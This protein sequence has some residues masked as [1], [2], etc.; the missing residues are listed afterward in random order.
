M[1][2]FWGRNIFERKRD[3]AGFGREGQWRS[4][5]ASPLPSPQQFAMEQYLLPKWVLKYK[6]WPCTGVLLSHWLRPSQRK[7][8]ISLKSE[9]DLRVLTAGNYQLTTFL[10]T[11]RELC[12]F[13]FNWNIVDLECSISFGVQQSESVIHIHVSTF[14]F[15]KILFPY[16]LLQSIKWSSLCCTVGPY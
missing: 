7:N 11:G 4:K 9:V 3:R 2:R 1:L 13:F 14:F 10:V 5:S 15:F 12:F 8:A 6:A 16:R